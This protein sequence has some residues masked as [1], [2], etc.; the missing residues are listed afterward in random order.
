[1]KKELIH[2]IAPVALS[3]LGLTSAQA[4]EQSLAELHAQYGISAEPD[5]EGYY[6]IYRPKC[7]TT[8]GT[9]SS[10][11]LKYKLARSITCSDPALV[12]NSV[13]FTVRGHHTEFNLNGKI[14]NCASDN[15]SGFDIG[16]QMAGDHG[17]LIGSPKEHRTGKIMNCGDDG[18][19]IESLSEDKRAGADE[20]GYN[21]VKRVEVQFSQNGF[22]VSNNGNELEDNIAENNVQY[23]FLLEILAKPTIPYLHGN[24]FIGN[25]ARDNGTGFFD[26]NNGTPD[27]H[28]TS[29]KTA[30]HE[31]DNLFI[32][33]TA[34]FNF[35]DGFLIIGAG[36]EFL[37]NYANQNGGD[38][39]EYDFFHDY[40]T[41]S[42]PALILAKFEGNE[43]F[44]NDYNGF[45]AD[46]DTD[47]AY[48]KNNIAL[49]NNQLEEGS[50]DLADDN[51][52][53]ASDDAELYGLN[54]WIRN[55]AFSADP[56]CTRGTGIV[57]QRAE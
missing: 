33:N 23:G 37:Y 1:M 32:D 46:F 3:I 39:F 12:K 21:K 16:V 44:N 40:T 7:G 43:A 17:V 38:G 47:G 24:K 50:S 42:N 15:E 10:E 4:A 22:Q 54:R 18:V 57:L 2:I 14:I 19:V 25:T 26:N 30:D 28:S 20:P 5:E 56:N 29:A 34:E 36:G 52:A 53:C 8:L 51:D 31:F 49:L 48:F 41:P 13:V 9:V 27:F 45:E 6:I 35:G 11:G 55:L